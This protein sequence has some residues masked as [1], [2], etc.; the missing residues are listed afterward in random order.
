MADGL[1]VLLTWQLGTLLHGAFCDQHLVAAAKAAEAAAAA[2]T[3]ETIM[4]FPLV[5]ARCTNAAG[6]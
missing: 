3:A 2:A 1:C 6:V 4:E 5:I